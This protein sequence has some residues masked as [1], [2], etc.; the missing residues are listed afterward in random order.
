MPTAGKADTFPAPSIAGRAL[1]AAWLPRHK[2]RGHLV[3]VQRSNVST[4]GITPPRESESC[5]RV[6]IS[7]SLAPPP[8]AWPPLPPA[9][10]RPA[11]APPRPGWA[12]RRPAASTAAPWP[13]R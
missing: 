5:P 1:R 9:S 6:A 4:A 11:P 12:T 3:T 7:S 13:P 2:A 8:V 10:P